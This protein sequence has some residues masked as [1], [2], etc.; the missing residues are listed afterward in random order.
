MKIKFN[1]FSEYLEQCTPLPWTFVKSHPSTWLVDNHSLAINYIRFKLIME[2]AEKYLSK[3]NEILDVG[4]YPGTVPVLF[5]EYLGLPKTSKY[6]GIGL[7]FNEEFSE[8][9]GEYEVELLECDLDHRL[10]LDNGRNRK[11]PMEAETVDSIIFT[12]V[13]EHFFDPFYP[14][15][16]INRVSKVD[17]IMILTTDNLT[18]WGGLLALLRGKSCNVPLIA[19]SLFYSGDWRPHFREYSRKEL[20]QLLKWAGFEIIEHKFY[21]AEFGSYRIVNGKLIRQDIEKLSFKGK[22]KRLIRDFAR[23][24]VPHLRDNHIIVARKVKSYEEMMNESPRI[25]SDMDDWVE[26]RNRFSEFMV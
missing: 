12:D 11:I 3:A 9:M 16:E 22:I 7:G 26:Q 1:S 13:I 23:K 6:Y 17:A 21:E 2:A 5:Y 14:L 24:T 15:Q 19:G 20:F 8:K 4:V 10:H 25:V 18:R